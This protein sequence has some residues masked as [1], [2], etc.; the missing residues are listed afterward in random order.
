M[1]ITPNFKGA[2]IFFPQIYNRIRPI[3]IYFT[4]VFIEEI[5]SWY[6]IDDDEYF[7]D[8]LNNFDVPKQ[9]VLIQS[10]KYWDKH[11][12]CRFI[13][14]YYYYLIFGY[15]HKSLSSNSSLQTKGGKKNYLVHLLPRFLEHSHG[16]K[17]SG[18]TLMGLCRLL[19]V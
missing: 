16:M 3:Y 1:T 11:N 2:H 15:L 7:L 5:A 12:S 9:I 6:S 8:K 13:Y 4:F 14:Y 19:M 18:V 10:F 17:Q